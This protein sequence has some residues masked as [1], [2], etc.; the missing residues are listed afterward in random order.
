MSETALRA[1]DYLPRDPKSKSVTANVIPIRIVGRHYD[2]PTAT[3]LL[4]NRTAL[5]LR[6]SVAQFAVLMDRKLTQR[7]ERYGGREA[8]I[9]RTPKDLLRDLVKEVK[10]LQESLETGT[11]VDSGLEAADVAN[12][13]MMIA[14]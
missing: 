13:A 11:W 10:E 3:L 5:P 14:D 9:R 2:E 1:H 12:Y 7:V 8:W 4:P 6:N